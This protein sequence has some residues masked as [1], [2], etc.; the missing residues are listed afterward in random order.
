MQLSTLL[1]AKTLLRENGLVLGMLNVALAFACAITFFGVL[2]A[3]SVFSAWLQLYTGNPRAFV[4]FPVPAL[5]IVYI[6][7]FPV[8]WAYFAKRMQPGPTSRAVWTGLAGAAPLFGIAL[9]GY[10]AVALMLAMGDLAPDSMLEAS[11]W[12]HG[13]LST[14]ILCA[15]VA[16][17]AMVAVFSPRSY[18]S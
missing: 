9:L 8:M 18:P 6:A 1:H 10:S 13:I 15:G 2:A 3:V 11:V 17:A 12:I 5:F 14:L 4:S 16:C 7:A